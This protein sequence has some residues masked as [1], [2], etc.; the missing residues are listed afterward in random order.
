VAQGA[1]VLLFQPFGASSHV[2]CEAPA[3]GGVQRPTWFPSPSQHTNPVKEYMLGCESLHVPCPEARSG[4]G[5]HEPGVA[6]PSNVSVMVPNS[7]AALAVAKITEE[8]NIFPRIVDIFDCDYFA[9][10]VFH[11]P[12]FGKFG[13]FRTQ[14]AQ[15]VSIF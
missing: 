8:A 6:V 13:K 1:F 9:I 2:G 3:A 7:H 10:F 14:K 15:K 5:Q 12:H 11:L 4:P